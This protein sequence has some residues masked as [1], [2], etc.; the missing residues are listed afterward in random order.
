MA[1]IINLGENAVLHVEIPEHLGLGW[2][3]VVVC[4]GQN[5]APLDFAFV[6]VPWAPGHRC[7]SQNGEPTTEVFLHVF[8]ASE[9]YAHLTPPGWAASGPSV[10]DSPLSGAPLEPRLT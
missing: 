7:R 5:A 9:M 8:A 3:Y 4:S 6:H 1:D 2:H 10:L